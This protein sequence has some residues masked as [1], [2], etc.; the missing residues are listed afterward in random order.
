VELRIRDDGRG[1]D[2]ASIPP[3]HLGVGIMRER[4]ATVGATLEIESQAG[5]GTQIVIVWKGERHLLVS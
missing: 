5:H 4:A 3:D 2:P 1:F